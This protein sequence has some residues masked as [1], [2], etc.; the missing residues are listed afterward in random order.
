MISAQLVPALLDRP[1]RV[2]VV[3]HKAGVVLDDP[4]RFAR[5]V[6]VDIDDSQDRH[7]C[8]DPWHTGLIQPAGNRTHR[9]PQQVRGADHH[10]ERAKHHRPAGQLRP[11]LVPLPAHDLADEHDEGDRQELEHHQTMH[12]V[13]VDDPVRHRV[14]LGP[15]AYRIAG[16]EDIELDRQP[17]RCACKPEGKRYVEIKGAFQRALKA[18][19]IEDFRFH[20]LRH[21]F[22]SSLVQRGVDLY[23]VQ[24]LLGHKD[25]RMTQRYAHLSPENLRDAVL[26]LDVKEEQTKNLSQF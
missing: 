15:P 14:H 23:Q 16:K 9:D 26:K 6:D 13:P 18:T 1:R 19:G 8:F 2:G 22:A 21:T 17:A 25:G 24:R 3:E 5:A 7:P 20:D 10:R 11:G 12:I 4:Q